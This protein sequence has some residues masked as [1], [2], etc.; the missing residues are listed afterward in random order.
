MFVGA[1]EFNQDISS[2]PV[3]AGTKCDS[4]FNGATKFLRN[5]CKWQGHSN[6]LQGDIVVTMFTGTKCNDGQ[7]V[8]TADTAGTVTNGV[9]CCTC[10]DSQNT[11]EGCVKA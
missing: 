9:I 11:A 6:F 7:D 8:P 10:A 5:L 3:K 2:W 4:M 1:A